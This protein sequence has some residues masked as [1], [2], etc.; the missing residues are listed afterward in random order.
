MKHLLLFYILLVPIILHAQSG[1]LD[2]DFSADG[3]VTLDYSSSD[4]GYDLAIQ[5]DGNILVCGSSTA[6]GM[7]MV[8]TRLLPDGSSDNSFGTGGTVFVDMG[9]T[10]VASAVIVQEDGKIILAGSSGSDFA[11]VRLSSDGSLDN[12]FSFDGKLVIPIGVSTDNASDVAITT[13]QKIIICGTDWEP[14]SSDVAVVRLN[15]DGS[16]DNTFSFDGIA[17]TNIDGN[18]NGVSIFA[19]PDGKVTVG[20]YS[21]GNSGIHPILIRYNEDGSLDNTFSTAGELL[22]DLGG[23]EGTFRDITLT[24]SGK[25]I[26]TGSIGLGTAAEMLVARF[27]TNGDPD[28]SFSFDGLAGTDFFGEE[29]LGFAIVLQPDGKILAG[30]YAKDGNKMMAM[31]RFDNDGNLDNTFGTNGLVT[32]QASTVDEIQALALQADGK[33]VAFGRAYTVDADQV[34]ARYIS[35]M[36]IGI[37]EVD[38]Y[39]GSTLVYPN[40]ITDQ[41]VIVEYEL[42]E[43][44][45]VSIHLMD[46]TGKHVST[47]LP[48]QLHTVGDHQKE[49]DL[50]GVSSG[51]YILGLNTEKGSMTIKVL[52]P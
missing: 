26:A 28:L 30:G 9:S 12:S 44:A 41:K 14:G 4:V 11:V 6:N 35:G 50:K 34:A 20:G 13:G 33:I 45:T 7:D 24:G 29:D 32:T 51:N 21:S 3:L 16:M 49:L 40:P 15:P 19:N 5:P 37:G 38:A 18:D 27:Q 17:T 22:V 47:L 10:S 52:I 1:S 46:V 23:E 2:S 36:N 43:K 48:E 39:I 8:V 31:L 42:R 25:I